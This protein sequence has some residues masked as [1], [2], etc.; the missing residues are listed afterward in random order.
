MGFLEL[1]QRTFC[2]RSEV[3]VYRPGII[4]LSK[5]G[6]LDLPDLIST[7][8]T[9]FSGNGEL[10][11]FLEPAQR[12]FCLRSEVSAYRPGIITLSKQGSLDLPDLIPTQSSS[13]LALLLGEGLLLLG[14]LSEPV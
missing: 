3:S 13:G 14:A 12:T 9:Y 7:H 6:S 8:S 2:L 1:A 4:T 11:G 10:L 5:Q